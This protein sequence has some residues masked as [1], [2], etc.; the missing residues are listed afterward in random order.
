MRRS[1]Q[2]RCRAPQDALLGV[3][4]AAIAVTGSVAP[5]QPVSAQPAA[6]LPTELRYVPHDA[7]LFLYA[8]ASKIWSHDV[9]KSFRAAD[10]NTF[11]MLEETATKLSGMKIEELKTVVVF[12]PKLKDP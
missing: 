4:V 10:K 3:L 11:G 9:T 6:Q 7:A 2:S 8:D 12:F 5:P 1:L